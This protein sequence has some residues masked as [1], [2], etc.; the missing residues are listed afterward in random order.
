MAYV[1]DSKSRVFGRGS[2]TL[3][4]PTNIDT[5]PR[6]ETDITKRYGRLIVGAIPAEGTIFKAL[7]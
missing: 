5:C 2:S 1:R 6:S 7:L 4:C 3:P